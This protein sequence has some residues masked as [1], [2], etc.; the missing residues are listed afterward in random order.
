MA[1]SSRKKSVELWQTQIPASNRE[2]LAKLLFRVD[3]PPGTRTI[4]GS[5]DQLGLR[6]PG[7]NKLNYDNGYWVISIESITDD[8][9]LNY[10]AEH[11][12]L[13]ASP[14]RPAVYDVLISTSIMT[15]PQS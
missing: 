13:V 9:I 6:L 15:V 8:A 10:I 11:L 1:T 2:E 5:Q 12:Y 4:S 7:L 14:S 3:K